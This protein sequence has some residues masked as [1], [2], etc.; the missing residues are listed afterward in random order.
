MQTIAW[1]YERA[2]LTPENYNATTTSHFVLKSLSKIPECST[3]KS[4]DSFSNRRC[5]KFI[6][7]QN[8]G[9]FPLHK[10]IFKFGAPVT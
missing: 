1:L 3:Y 4:I 2:I 9:G 6:N 5:S 8:P 7:T 10:L